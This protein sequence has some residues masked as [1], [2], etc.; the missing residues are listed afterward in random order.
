MSVGPELSI[1]LP[2]RNEAENIGRV[3]RGLAR[4]VQTPHEVLVV[5]D[6]DEDSTVPVVRAL[7]PELPQVRLE[8]NT[9]GRGV[10]SAMRCG[11]DAARGELILISMADGSD[12]PEIVDRMVALARGGAAV[13]AASRYVHG[14]RQL[15]GPRLKGLL[16]RMAGLS[17]H[18]L[19]GLPI[20]DATSNFRLY[21]RS[22][23]ASV[24]IESRAGFE[25]ALELTVKAHRAGHRLAEV[26]TTWRDRTAGTSGFQ[27]RRWLPHYLRW[28]LLAFARRP[29]TISR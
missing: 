18:V 12:E 3:L 8:R 16:S 27:L 9:R 6:V 17:L 13:V 24:T 26:P 20:H 28:Y 19:A 2:V 21:R 5:Y 15:G 14:G 23:L 22:F 7:Q 1:V 11:I 10:L 4:A 29:R 25:L